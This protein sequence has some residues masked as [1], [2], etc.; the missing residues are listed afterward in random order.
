MEDRCF[1]ST[2]IYC[3]EFVLLYSSVKMCLVFQSAS[4]VTKLW[5]H[6][7]HSTEYIYIFC[8]GFFFSAF[9]TVEKAI[10]WFRNHIN[11]KKGLRKH[12]NCIIEG[13]C[14]VLE[15]VYIFGVGIFLCTPYSQQNVYI[16]F[17]V[18]V[19]KREGYCCGLFSELG[20]F[21]FTEVENN[22][23]WVC[24]CSWN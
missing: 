20:M 11:E 22:C 7:I 3:G 21:L 18:S 2:G 17:V 4:G 10:N 16:L 9:Q 15:N 12:L 24:S 13:L 5:M 6:Q 1:K 14:S 19:S 23:N 8:C